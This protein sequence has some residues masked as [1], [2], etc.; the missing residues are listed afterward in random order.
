MSNLSILDSLVLRDTNNPPLI[1]KQA[2]LTYAEWDANLVAIY[3]VIQDVVSGDNVTVYNPATVYDSAS[4]NV[5]LKYAGY[6]GRIWQAIFVGTF[7]SQTPAE[8][9]YW[10]QITL[11]QLFPDVLKLAQVSGGFGGGGTLDQAYDSGGSGVGRTIIADTGAVKVAGADGLLVTG[12]IGTGAVSEWVGGGAYDV[13]MFFNPKKGA[14]RAGYAFASEWNDANIGVGSIG[15][16]SNVVASAVN[17]TALGDGTI[18]SGSNSTAIGNATI[19]SG[20]ASTAIGNATIASGDTSTAMGFETTA[21]GDTSTAIGYKTTALSFVETVIGIWN[22]VYAP[23]SAIA[24]NAADRLF[25]I[26]NGQSSAARSDA[27]VVLKS[28]KITCPSTTGSFTPNVLTTAERNALTA[29]AGMFI[30]NSTTNK[31]QGYDG[32]IWN[33]Q[34]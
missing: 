5:Y 33:D 1:D 27:F 24:W 21:S 19:A 29:T 14:F 4:T 23:V 6:D 32:S 10:T 12:V 34:Y 13:G 9:I 22:T 16:G 28:G 2:E 8:G 20:S 30:Y 17:S 3:N 26:A 18:A 25:S 31:H 11:A 7:S 15:I